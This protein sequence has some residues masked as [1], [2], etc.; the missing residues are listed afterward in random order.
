MPREEHTSKEATWESRSN[1]RIGMT[2]YLANFHSLMMK[3]EASTSPKMI[4]QTT[5]G[6]DHGKDT[7]PNSSPSKN[8]TVPPT[9]VR[10]PSQSTALRPA[11]T[12]VRGLCSFRLNRSMKKVIAVHGTEEIVRSVNVN[13]LIKV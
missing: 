12:G 2:G 4:R 6:D 8:M 1:S 13:K 5:F 10:L 7:P 9:T 11:M 3:S